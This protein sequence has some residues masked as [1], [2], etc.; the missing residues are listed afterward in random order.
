M[1]TGVFWDGKASVGKYFPRR[2]WLLPSSGSKRPFL[3]Y[4]DLKMEAFRYFETSATIYQQTRRNIPQDPTIQRFCQLRTRHLNSRSSFRRWAEEQLCG[5]VGQSV[6]QLVSHS[7]GQSV[8]RSVSQSV[9]QSVG[10]S[11][12]QSVGHSVS[13][14]DSQSVRQ[15]VGQSVGRSVSQ[16]VGQSV[17]R[18]IS[19]SANQSVV[20]S[21]D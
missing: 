3:D 12:S 17:S 9:G 2:S 19:Q 18:P 15:S 7:V 4:T 5:A 13:R 1:K 20:Q 8:G 21:V 10:R 11:V 6:N 16:S 14:S